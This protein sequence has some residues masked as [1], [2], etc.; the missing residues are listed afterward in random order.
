MSVFVA[1][2]TGV[3]GKNLVPLLLKSAHEMIALARTPQ[4]AK[5][6]ESLGAKA[7]VVAD[8]L[9]RDALIGVIRRA[10]PE[11]IIHQLTALTGVTSFKK[12]DDEF[13]PTNRLRAEGTETFGRAQRWALVTSRSAKSR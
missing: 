7:V 1:G 4:K 12:L 8:G 10:Q 11:V 13:A 2:G 3:V 5:E 9:D 6:V